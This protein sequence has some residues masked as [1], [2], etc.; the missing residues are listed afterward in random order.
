M[1]NITYTNIKEKVEEIRQNAST[2]LRDGVETY[3]KS[4][5][6]AIDDENFYYNIK[7]LY[8]E[9]KDDIFEADVLDAFSEFIYN[10]INGYVHLIDEFEKAIESENIMDLI[11]S[12]RYAT[13]PSEYIRALP[14]SKLSEVI[15]CL[16][17]ILNKSYWN[18]E[19]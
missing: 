18:L 8:Q 17:T 6:D 9:Y 2:M 4:F 16:K 7:S 10:H 5:K 13:T 15:N 14:I 12:L 3:L 19:E 11:I 1:K